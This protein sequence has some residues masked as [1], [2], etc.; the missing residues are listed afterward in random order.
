MA[1]ITIEDCLN[2]VENRFAL[3]H[4]ASQRARQLLKGSRQLVRSKNKYIV[5]SLREIASEKVH[6][7]NQLNEKS[8]TE[9]EA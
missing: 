1:R 6:F 4:L 5:T 2:Q 7:A 9:D 3:V 8:I